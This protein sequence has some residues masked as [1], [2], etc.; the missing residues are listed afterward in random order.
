MEIPMCWMW[1][2]VLFNVPLVGCLEIHLSD[3][4]QP[5]TLL[6]NLSLGP[7][8]TSKLDRTL[9][10]KFIQSFF[11]VGRHDG[12]IRLSRK[13]QCAHTARNPAPVYFRTVSWTS[14]DD[15]LTQFNVFVHGQDC[16]IK[17]KRKK[18]SGKPDIHI[19]H[20]T[21]L[22]AT[23]CF[24]SGKLL[25]N[26]TERLP[27][28]T[29]TI[30]F[31]DSV[32]V[33]KELSAV[34]TRG[35]L[36]LAEDVCLERRGQRAVTLQCALRSSARGGGLSVLLRLTLV[37][38]PQQLEFVPQ[39]IQKSGTLI[40]RGKRQAN[41]SPQFQLPNYQVSIPENE[42]AGTRVITLKATD[43]DDGDAGRLEYSMEA[44]F[45]SRSNDF[46]DIDSRTGS[47]TTVQPLDREV[48]D[49]HVFKVTVID[50]GSPI[51]SATTYLT[52]TVSDTNDHRP[53]FEQ[54]E[55]RVSIRENVETGFEVMTIRATDGDAPSNANMIY[56]I[57][58]GDG[59]NSLFEIDSRNGLVRIR[60]RPDRETRA[61]YQL[62]VEANDQGK[63]P[64]PRSATATVKITVEDEND[65]YPQFT[66]KR[67]VVQI[68]ENVAV[69]T[70][71][72]QVDAKD[73]DEGN[74][75][76]VHFSIISG[77]VKGQFYIHSP[78]GVID[79]INPLDYEM[80]REY[81]LRI[82]A[83][84]GG[85]PPLIN[86]TGMVVVQ[87]VDV[88]DNAPMFVSTPF[89]AS[90]LENVAVGYSVIHIQA[91][92]SD[93]G[94]NALLEYRLTDTA[95]G[96]PFTINNSTG[97]ITVS[98]ELDRETT[99]F[100]T[101]GVEA[102]D[103]GIPVMSSS[104]SV[105]ITVLDVNDN[106]PTFTEK[107]YSLK[108]NEDAVVG[109]SVLTMTAVDRDINSVVT[110]QISSGNT[111]NRFAITSQ[112]GGGLITLALPLDYKQER[113]YVLTVTASDGTRYD[114][115][116]VFINVTDANTHRPVFQ[117][118]NYQITLCED[119]PVGS[120][121]VMISA[122]DEDTGENAR[123][124]YVMEDNVPQFK[125]D[126]DTGAITTQMEIDYEDQASYTLA[127]IARDNGIPQK[128]DTTYVEIIILDANDNTPHFLRDRYR[129]TVFEDAAV[130]TSVLQISASD[131]DSGSNSRVSY[132]FQGGDD[133]EG[134]FYIEPYS[135]II[136]TARK[137]DR[138]NVPVYNLKAYAVDR[139]VPPL[140]ASVPVHVVVQD[141]NDN[142][143]V[144][145]K[146]VL[147]IDVE[148][149]SPVGS[150]VARITA[151]DPD[152]G[153]NAQIMYQ[154]VEGNIPEVFQLNI[155]NGDL[156]A[157]TDLDYEA[158]TEYVI[159]VQ[160]TSAPLVS[161]ATVHVRLLDMNDNTPVLQ[162]F[163]I[164]F[165]NYI[166]NKSNSFP[167][168]IIGKVP[169]HDPDVSDKLRYKFES[170]NELNLLLLNEDTGDL[171][172]SRDLDNDRT[173]EAPMTISVSDGL[174]H[175]VALC[176]L[177]VTIITDD[178]LTNS[179]TVRLENMSQER[180]LSPLLS[181]FLEG[182]AAVLS[183]KREAVFVFNIQND[184][185][186]QGSILNVTFS[187][188]QPGGA[189]GY[190]AFFPSEELQEHIYL[191][192]TLL[193]MISSQEVL[194]FDDNIC[195][196]EPCE[197]YMKCVSVLKFDSSPPFIASDTVL[198]RPI[199]PI[200]GLRCRC[201]L[202]FT[203]D[204]CETEIDLC[205]SGP[206]KNNGRCRSR[207]G[208]Y[209]CECMEDF[210]GEHCEVNVSSGRCEPGVC[211]N[212][213]QC[214][215][216]LA[217][218]FMCQCS[219]GEFEKP[220]CEMTT[221]SF[222]GQS[223]I[224]F[225]GLRQRFHF[226]VSF[227]FAT[228]ERSALLLYNGRFNEKHDFIALE[229]IDE[230]VQLTFSGGETKTTVFPYIPG[231]VSDGQWHSVQLHYYNK[232]G[233]SLVDSTGAL[234]L[235]LYTVWLELNQKEPNIGRLG[236]PHGPSEEKVAVVAVDD[237]DIS[238]AI[239]F[240][241]QIGNY[242]C[243]AQ[244][245]QTGQKKSL[246][247]TGPL[248]LGGVPN[249]PEDFP[250]GN[251]DFVGCMR[252]LSIDSKPIDMA[253]YVANNGTEA[254]CPTKKNFCMDDLCQ[255]GG[256]C[257][258][259]WDTHSCDCPTGYGGKNC[260]QV[261]PSPQFFDG[262][263]LVSWSET[264]ITI[265]IPWFMGLMFRTRQ[266]A[267]TLMQ[268]NAGAHATINLMVREQHVRMEVFRK[269]QLVAS[270]GFPQVRVNDGEWHHLLVELR[271][272]KDGKDIK[273]IAYV[274]LDYG[275]YQKSVELGNDLPGLKL[276]T[277]HVGGLPGE[278]NQVRKGFVGCIQG[279][280]M[281]ETPTNVANVNMAQGLKIRVEDGCDLAD[282]CD[283]NICP[284]NSHCSDDWSTHTCVCDPG[285]F[286]K[287]CVDACQLNPCEHV[288]TCVR[289]PS[290]SHGYT[291]E[292][293]QNH[294]G[295][296]CE[297]K[298]EK[299]CPQ[300]WWGSP[301]CGPCNCDTNRG[302]HKDCNK[303]TGECRCKENHYRPE[304]EDTCYPCE[305]FSLGSESRTCDTITG[306]CPCKGGV[307]G[308][309]C[310][311]C[312]NPFAEVT[313]TGCEV[314]YEGCPKAFDA[315]IWWP[316]TKFG[317]PA[318]M[319]CPKGS[320]G[321]A[322]RHCNDEKGWLSPELFNCT[323]VSFSQLKKLNEDLRRNSSRMD[324]E[325][326]KTIVRLLHSATDNIQRYYGN[327]V[328]TA[329]QLLNHVL[330]YE[331]RQ[332]GFDLT[333]MRDAKFNENLVRAGSAI[334]D[335]DTKEHWEQIQKT[336]GGTANLLRN[337]EDYANTLAQNVRKTYLKPFTIVTDNM[338]LTVDYL[339]VSDPEKATLPRFQ[340]IHEEYSKDLGS[341]V[342]F[343]QFNLRVQGHRAEPNYEPQSQTD[344]PQEEEHTASERRR[345]YI[346]PA[347]PLPVAVVIVYK[348]MG[349]LLP[350]S[351][352]PDRRS[353]R[354][355]NRPV[356]NTAIVSATVHS[357]GP[358]L[359]PLLEPPITLEYT[360]LETEERTKPVCVFWNH[361][362]AI[363]GTGGWSAK[364][365]EVLNRNNSHISCQCNH[366]TSFAVLMD[367]SKR[368]HGDVLPMKI[369]T[370][371]TVSVSLCLLLLTFILLCLL[372]RLHSNLHAI[373]RNLIA[374][375][376]F[377]ELVFL[378]GIN[379][380]DNPFVCM[381]I[382]IL[383]H[384]FYMCTFAW[385]FVEGL[386]IYRMLTELRNINHGHMRFYYAMG[387]GIPA[388]IT[389]LAVG[390]DPQGYGNPD[391][392]WLSVHDTLIWSFAGPIFVV[393]LVNI[394][395]FILAAKASCGRRQK[396]VEKS[397]AIP[398]LRMAFLLLLFIGATW[399]LG[400]M[401]VNSDVMTFHYLFAAFSCLQGVFIFFFHVILNKEVMKN[402]K[403]VFT[404][405]KSAPDE[406]STTRASLLTRSLNCNTTY[407]EDGQLY[408][409]G[410]GESTVSLDSTLRSAKSRSSYLP[411]TLR[412]ESGQK[413]SVS[414]GTVKG[415]TDLDGTLFHRNGTKGD[416]SDSDSELS[417]D[418]H[419]SS[420]ASSHSS[421]SEDD[422]IDV[423]PKWNNERQ[424]VHS[425]P[426]VDSVSNHVKPYWPAE[427]T[428]ASDSED[429]GGAERL[430]VETK[431]NVELHPENKLNHVG[432]RERETFPERDTQ[433]AGNARDAAPSSQ[434]HGN[435][436]QQ[437]EQRKGIL[438]NKISYPPPLNDKN[439]KNR[440]REKL[441]DY[442]TPTITSP[443]PNNHHHTSSPTLPSV[444]I[445]SPSS[446]PPSP[447]SNDGGRPGNHD[448][449]SLVKPPVAP[450]P[451]M[452]TG[453]AG[454]YRETNGGVAMHLKSGTVNGGNESDSEKTQTSL[455]L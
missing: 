392:C 411:Y 113:Q 347:A 372:R 205:Y 106:V 152:E 298:V 65:N 53:V 173:L 176:T 94:E 296:Y 60:E 239:R 304:G 320:I 59:V 21:K 326:S 96:F 306:Q 175:V 154:I 363:G 279:V 289:K 436:N 137:L 253:S 70:R 330:L 277:L 41:A 166:T 144:F 117:S 333:A 317:R 153:T 361:T 108:I 97:W 118:A 188:L 297:N 376:F 303:T 343:P 408:R 364:G 218:G 424:P 308:R 415:H 74:N 426:K 281:G 266:P 442:N 122:T 355:P 148:E 56:K 384:Y 38:V 206:C 265:A 381:V 63:D 272:A 31:S 430:R 52:V 294:Y 325:H 134:D 271:S 223:F 64:G 397:G 213:G 267:G 353:L 261:M 305:C 352:D 332:E 416:D 178:M 25:L 160:A 193:R 401:A 168:G 354:L 383:L 7:G 109:T 374:A 159:V 79:I 50:N 328:K 321:T 423:K 141:I 319:N 429:P 126:S 51:R 112:S 371:T 99:D 32:C 136:R 340:D 22:E 315:D 161:R 390:L 61:K 9:S 66:E 177:R 23:S 259:R 346:E 235:P 233:G 344:A 307:I 360:L 34:F 230:Q 369:V 422:D 129:G 150:V 20:L 413:P 16:F 324:S 146:D 43:P 78:T 365:C 17:Y 124:T 437:P 185:D 387:W 452:A 288:S 241:K 196:R 135:G 268:A 179:I 47:I 378:L 24:P 275:M 200:N 366:M 81:N 212:G 103:H 169:A 201:P 403:N 84:D 419:S 379:Q 155:F 105:S 428:T 255:N 228:R 182:V 132:T 83:Q 8:W 414:S 163:E 418:E 198:F 211:K 385:M 322:I 400:L 72:I 210:T 180:F 310:N 167:A 35:A 12:L 238:M 318:A 3:T 234:R 204:Y 114:T 39:S 6:A 444:N 165:N 420:Y 264:D 301:M 147:F 274:S 393:V 367:I 293:G 36:F 327:D 15:I 438:K 248:L 192:R 98:E 224:T 323:T 170:G 164:I 440:L 162:D 221:R 158:K 455:P 130:F 199:H 245:T 190:G 42:P 359:P 341:S 231:G 88:N 406:S 249:L 339:D 93:S 388:I 256:V 404:G 242:S 181:R 282:P 240:G 133:G 295:Q 49:T 18:S 46:F 28:F 336:E 448:H 391:F 399:M 262:Q 45:D 375:L 454:L 186:V 251:R 77:N 402:L 434:P 286:G 58:N 351:Y 290:S 348:S 75:G 209:T 197:N 125:I 138:E 386:H 95:P 439:M 396:A 257:V 102:R 431:V 314:V 427:A 184:T 246:D 171:R 128:S 11:Q 217:G 215:N 342:Q 13:V 10:P 407:T 405:K 247:L 82:K 4:L 273:Y 183:T 331:S 26:V 368:E 222:P 362:V 107:V 302:F 90:V 104:A 445:M 447:A 260:E 1:V 86:G 73:T 55:Y 345:R 115:A 270:L 329:A 316:K 394:V 119:K 207:E 334:L 449:S 258:S 309:Q 421:D 54:T 62:I 450:R 453:P 220:Y 208:G 232:G 373:H 172:L 227:M 121:A 101:F 156:T 33:G 312:D 111:R 252:N 131:R 395:I 87:V 244:G 311:R 229:I 412:E 143:P 214:V 116:Q 29:R 254:G 313:P 76:K 299:P 409:S 37:K 123:I 194:P 68:P 269:Q 356:I 432:D 85:R 435:S 48:K 283:S 337:F 335:P 145:E 433:P 276:Q 44:L 380:T 263:A 127:I 284:E 30:A 140:K 285:F 370:Y 216:R 91:I 57:V 291:C 195:L 425:T 203:G 142:A 89:Q 191:N 174:H 236:I 243:A 287:E 151:S 149:N 100:Y 357:E 377:S 250:V 187:A 19:T 280:R 350:E 5:G 338:I 226:T 189:S 92:D 237:C 139:G 157:L 110:Y 446:R 382:A 410:I 417:V 219:P 67:Y 40:R 441:S 358:P 451:Q 2:C 14:G 225:R 278:G 398:A 69:N 300:G 202:G 443:P 71:V 349:K 80:I 120:V 292:C 389:G 27:T